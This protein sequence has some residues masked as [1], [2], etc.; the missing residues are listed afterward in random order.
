MVR[1]EKVVAKTSV[2]SGNYRAAA[3]LTVVV[4]APAAAARVTVKI[5]V[6]V[7]IY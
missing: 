4:I 1:V 5:T 6:T 3:E 7:N 2:P